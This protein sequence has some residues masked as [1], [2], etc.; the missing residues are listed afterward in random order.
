MLSLFYRTYVLTYAMHFWLFKTIRVLSLYLVIEVL[1]QKVAETWNLGH[2][3]L[4]CDYRQQQSTGSHPPR[5]W[6]A[7]KHF[8]LASLSYKT[9]K[10]E[11]V[12][13]KEW[14]RAKT[15]LVSTIS[16]N[17]LYGKAEQQD[18]YCYWFR[19]WIGWKSA[20]TQVLQAINM[21]H[22]KSANA[23]QDFTISFGC[24]W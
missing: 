5:I 17:F 18:G 22:N 11:W 8:P 9:A 24:L 10:V 2:H 1:V 16:R 6:P 13:G 4:P 21:Q 20:D 23:T 15:S 3:L 19:E 14:G 12:T 7:P